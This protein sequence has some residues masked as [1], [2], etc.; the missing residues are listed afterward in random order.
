LPATL[1]FVI[2]PA[3]GGASLPQ[4]LFE[5]QAMR[6]MRV[7]LIVAGAA[8]LLGACGKSGSSADT[9][10]STAPSSS[11][12]PAP[13]ESSGPS[14]EQVKALLAE[15]PAPYN[16]GDIEDGQAKFAVCSSCHTVTKGGSDMTGPNLHGVFARK[17]GTKEGYAYSDAMKAAAIAWDAPTLDKWIENPKALVPGTKMSYIGMHDPQARINVVAYLKVATSDAPAAH[18]K[19][20]AGEKHDEDDKA[21]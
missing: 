2:A 6:Q 15:L 17:G 19:D 7:M 13:A 20:D 1:T 21:K 18:D 10:A 8:A 5:E 3:G 16:T 9:S 4:T 11:A 12:A 14:P